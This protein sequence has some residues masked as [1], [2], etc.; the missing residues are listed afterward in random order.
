MPTRNMPAEKNAVDKFIQQRGKK[1]E[2]P[3]DWAAVHIMAYPTMNDLPEELNNETT[4]SYYNGTN[5]APPAPVEPPSINQLAGNVQSADQRLGELSGGNEALRVLQEA[6]REKSNTANA[7]LGESEIFKQAGVGGMGALSA[8]LASRGSE[9]QT[10]FANFSNIIGQMAGT[11]KDMANTALRK[12]E[13]AYRAYD[14]EKER[15]DAI[16]KDM[17][18]QE[19]AIEL[20]NLKHQFDSEINDK[21]KFVAGTKT[22]PA[23]YF[24]SRTGQFTAYDDTTEML[25]NDG[26]YIIAGYDIGNY[27]TAP[28]HEAAISKIMYDIGKFK[29]I[30]EVQKHISARAP[31][32]PVTGD[33]IQKASEKY[34]V[35]WE[36]LA[37][38]MQQD[39]NFADPAIND[40]GQRS[41]Q[42]A[43]Q[44]AYRTMNPGNVG[45]YTGSEHVYDSWQEGV[46]AV[47][48]NLSKRKVSDERAAAFEQ[49][50]Q[51]IEEKKEA[52]AYRSKVQELPIGQQQAAFDVVK[53][54]KDAKEIADLIDGGVETGP[55]AGRLLKGLDIFGFPITPDKQSFEGGT[56]PEEDALLAA[57]TAFT[58]SYMNAI[59][60]VA[61]G[62][63]EVKRL[64]KTLPDV[65][66]QEGPNKNSLRK[67]MKS[68]QGLY[69]TQL[70]IDFK[71]YPELLP[72]IKEDEM[73]EI[74]FE[75]G[76]TKEMTRG[77]AKRKGYI[78]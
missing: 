16:D 59:S 21:L 17:R 35:S 56:T 18:D 38:I 34:G 46:D 48:K 77:A 24:N 55:I 75:D 66:R 33:M 31:L 51:S 67:L 4:S 28:N 3:D 39:S 15:L 65:T 71:D 68:L 42:G 9:I 12:Y 49:E 44:W 41:P 58:A 8:S 74:Q 76:S 62:N 73:I 78:E 47:A 61:V 50:I 19:Q 23:G 11:Y 64:K 69:E 30:D 60:G 52:D 29:T 45:N 14:D 43:R 26:P 1:P 70:G 7:P 27:A 6:I 20:L 10:N 37:S 63:E 72:Q 40:L 32:S 57:T 13:S 22:Q 5:S 25:S 54:H 36:I 53:A 2:T